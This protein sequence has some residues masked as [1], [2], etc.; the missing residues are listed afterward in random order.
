MFCVLRTNR[1][2][3]DRIPHLKKKRKENY[4]DSLSMHFM[5]AYDDWSKLQIGH[6]ANY[7]VPCTNVS[8]TE[9]AQQLYAVL[10]V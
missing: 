7:V 9:C 4:V 5:L 1:G 2:S 6:T 10:W 3:I 8:G